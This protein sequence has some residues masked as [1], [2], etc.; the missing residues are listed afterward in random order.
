MV[1]FAFEGFR[2][3]AEADVMRDVQAREVRLRGGGCHA[4]Q[5]AVGGVGYARDTAEAASAC[6]FQIE[7]ELR[8]G[9]GTQAEKQG[10]GKRDITLLVVLKT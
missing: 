9:G 4:G 1:Y 8:V 2:F 3:G 6:N 10:G 7:I 5:F